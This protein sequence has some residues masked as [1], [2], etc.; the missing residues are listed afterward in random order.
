MVNSFD[1]SIYGQKKRHTSF[2]Q[3]LTCSGPLIALGLGPP[4]QKITW[5]IVL[6]GRLFQTLQS[7]LKPTRQV[8]QKNLLFACVKTS[9]QKLHQMYLNWRKPTKT[10]ELPSTNSVSS[11]MVFWDSQQKGTRLIWLQKWIWTEAKV[12]TSV[13]I[14]NWW[15]FGTSINPS[16]PKV[17]GGVIGWTSSVPENFPCQISLLKVGLVQVV[18]IQRKSSQYWRLS[19]SF[20]GFFYCKMKRC[21]PWIQ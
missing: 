10:V 9:G 6:L 15:N 8:L 1:K 4:A 21:C 11:N 18:Y 16:S 17:S 14:S 7:S 3:L 12:V 19:L 20:K 13:N 2:Q 5:Q